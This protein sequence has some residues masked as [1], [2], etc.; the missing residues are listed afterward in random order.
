M[1]SIKRRSVA[2]FILALA[3]IL[4]SSALLIVAVSEAQSETDIVIKPTPIKHI[5]QVIGSTQSQIH[6]ASLRDA[7]WPIQRLGIPENADSSAV[8]IGVCDT[9]GSASPDFGDNIKGGWNCFDDNADYHDIGH[10]GTDILH[11]LVNQE[12]GA[13]ARAS[14]YVYRISNLQSNMSLSAFDKAVDHAVADGVKIL[15][16]SWGALGAPPS[17][18]QD[19]VRKARSYGMIIIAGS[20]ND[21]ADVDSQEYIWNVDDANVLHVAASG[22]PGNNAATDSD[23]LDAYSNHGHGRVDL[24]APGQALGMG[25]TDTAYHWVN[26]TSI[27]GPWVAVEVSL[28][29]SQDPTRDWRTVRQI[30]LG[31]VVRCSELEMK[32]FSE[33]RAA[34]NRALAGDFNVPIDS[35]SIQRLKL[36][37][38]KKLS[39]SF[40]TTVLDPASVHS[41]PV[42]RVYAGDEL[43][44]ILT[45]SGD[46]LI[47]GKFAQVKGIQVNSSDGG[48]DEKS[49]P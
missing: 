34:V 39:L 45:Q 13:M 24:A 25:S 44:G 31:T 18:L 17:M 43:I 21:S 33:G 14:I 3:A 7:N 27:A 48:K 1:A 11:V 37:K 20:G 49:L 19:S 23:Q 16:C 15:I 29:W 28:V 9:G 46:T 2:F 42:Y 5:T 41:A 32:V 47:K 8:K 35:V 6:T 12:F 22:F 40:D 30:V 10:H 4:I 36:K 26:G 38:T